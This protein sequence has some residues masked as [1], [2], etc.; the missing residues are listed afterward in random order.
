MADVIEGTGEELEAYL[1]RQPK[2]RFRL[3]P[4]ASEGKDRAAEPSE[5]EIAQADA[6]LE[7]AIVSLGYATGTDN[8][9][10]DA[11]IAREYADDHAH[12]YAKDDAG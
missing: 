8:E 2:Q 7:A 11:D 5:E 10:L 6:Q 12:V 3:I 1:K 4:L 9:S